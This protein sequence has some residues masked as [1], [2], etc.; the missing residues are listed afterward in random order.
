[1]DVHLY[2]ACCGLLAG[3]RADSKLIPTEPE[4]QWQEPGLAVQ[5]HLFCLV[6]LFSEDVCIQLCVL[7]DFPLLL[8]PIPSALLPTMQELVKL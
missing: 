4:L 5:Q 1:M 6:L 8:H 7:N 2:P 3:E